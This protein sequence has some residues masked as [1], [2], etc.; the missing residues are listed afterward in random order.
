M[1]QAGRPYQRDNPKENP[2]QLPPG[3]LA[4]GYFD[5]KGNVFPEVIEKWPLELANAFLKGKPKLNTA[6]LRRFY[7]KVRDIKEKLDAK[8]PFDTLKEQI[9]ALGPLAAA[10]VG[11]ETAPPL[12]KEFIDRNIPHAVKSEAHFTRGFILHFQGIVAYA[13]FLDPKQQG[14]R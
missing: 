6:Q 8:Q 10:A 3:Y 13:K 7:N 1:N 11:R 4:K 2:P 12:F 9:Y 14:G 5:E